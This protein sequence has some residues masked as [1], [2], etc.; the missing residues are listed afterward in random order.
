MNQYTCHL[1]DDIPIEQTVY[2]VKRMGTP[3][4]L[5]MTERNDR[6]ST[7]RSVDTGLGGCIGLSDYISHQT[8][9][10]ACTCQFPD[11]Y[12]LPC[13]HM[14]RLAFEQFS[15]LNTLINNVKGPILTFIHH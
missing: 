14:L 11:C 2:I 15:S 7:L 5:E 3:L 12:G 10:A 8:T 13:R 9:L 4:L 6:D 1:A